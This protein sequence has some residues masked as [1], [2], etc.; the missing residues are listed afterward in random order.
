MRAVVVD[1]PHPGAR[2]AEVA[3]PVLPTGEVRVRV[4]EVGV[5]GTDR[6]IAAGLYGTPPPGSSELIVGHENLGEVVELGSGAAGPAVGTLV[7][8]TVRRGCGECRF[9]G[10]GRSDFCE[11]GRFTERGISG[12]DGFMAEE[13]ADRP[14][15]LVEV[16]ATLRRVAVLLEPLSV[17]EK[18]CTEGLAILGRYESAGVPPR[19]RPYRSLITG[20]GAIGMLAAF[21]LVLEGHEVTVID[22]HGPATAAAALLARV[23]AQHVDVHD[24]LG[25]LGGARVDLV[26]E[27][28]GSAEL[29]LELIDTLAPNAALVLTGI[30]SAGAPPLSVPAGRLL[31][32]LVLENQAIVGSVNANRSFFE[33]GVRHLAALQ[34]RFGPVAEGLITARRPLAE[35]ADA[36][37]GK[38]SGTIK[39]VLAVG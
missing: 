27:A 20:T 23:G 7:V 4:L 10:S 22:R 9:C 28:S 32:G 35:F 38:G 25:A 6:D 39:T 15:Y 11:S 26:I 36:L 1:P 24:G 21:R 33:A 37:S 3:P 19:R 12:R 14:E 5:C 34:A 17:V 29:D 16:P 18:A 13:Y 2:L 8:A 31:R 30:P